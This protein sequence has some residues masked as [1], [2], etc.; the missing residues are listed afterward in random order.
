M[1]NGPPASLKE[2]KK[3][4]RMRQRTWNFTEVNSNNAFKGRGLL[5]WVCVGGGRNEK[6]G[7]QNGRL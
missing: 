6:K 3:I 1:P 7:S 4:R 5:D 2:G